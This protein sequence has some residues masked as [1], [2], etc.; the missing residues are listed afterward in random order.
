M[1]Y[2]KKF[3]NLNLI[4]NWNLLLSDED[5]KKYAE[6]FD[7]IIDIF[8]E[9]RDLDYDIKFET[10]YGSRV[11]MS[12][13][14]YIDKNE[15]YEEFIHGLPARG[16]F[17]SISI[18]MEFDFNNFI[19]LISDINQSSTRLESLDFRIKSFDIKGDP[20]YKFPSPFISIKYEFESEIIPKSKDWQVN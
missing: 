14:D 1:K 4:K 6:L 15:K 5:F 20:L 13:D 16:L 19:K 3:E 9:Y 10:A 11:S 2:L 7:H 8:I 12:F 17:F 18:K